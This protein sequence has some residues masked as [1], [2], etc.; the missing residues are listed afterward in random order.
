MQQFSVVLKELRLWF[1]S[2]KWY[3][4]IRA[5][6]L[7]LLFG[8]LGIMFLYQLLSVVMPWQSLKVL[9][10]LFFT[11][12]L[13]SLANLAFLLGVWLTL[14][15]PNVKYLPYG[16]WGR[17]LYV[18]FPFTSISLSSLISVAVYAFLGY[19]LF[20]YTATSY[21]EQSRTSSLD[22]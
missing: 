1:E 20:K 6:A 3:S 14:I 13:L 12:P 18:I 21:A 22:N 16:L 10:T 11:I 15:S 5:Y 9:N 17:A 7:H 2:F 4:A 19:M 8:G